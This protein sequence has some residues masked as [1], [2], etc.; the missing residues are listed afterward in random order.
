MTL[1]AA[2]AEFLC[3]AVRQLSPDMR[4]VF[5]ERL[6]EYLQAIADPDVG[7]VD[8]ALRAAWTGLWTP[9]LD[10]D[11]RPGRWGLDALRV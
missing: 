10:L 2:E 1:P 11:L 6:A 3:S 7:D 4:P 5:I 8:R 9:P